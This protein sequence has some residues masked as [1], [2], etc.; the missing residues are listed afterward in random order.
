L[1][2]RDLSALA[3]SAFLASSSAAQTLASTLL[4]PGFDAPLAH[5]QSLARADWS[6]RGE[7]APSEFP[8]S[9]SQRSWDDQIC[10]ARFESLV[11]SASEGSS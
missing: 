1:G 9:G 7:A 6:A 8:L 10:S 5:L 2:V 4:P 3:S 11:G